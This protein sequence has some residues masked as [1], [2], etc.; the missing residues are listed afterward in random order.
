MHT[1]CE[2]CRKKRNGL[3]DFNIL[4]GMTQSF[5]KTHIIQIEEKNNSVVMI[6]N[7]RRFINFHVVSYD[8]ESSKEIESHT[9][10]EVCATVLVIKYLFKYILKGA[11]Q[12][13]GG[14]YF[15]LRFMEKATV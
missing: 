12:L 5:S 7:G 14:G 11:D 4:R 10:V 13:T 3:K 8:H 6:K 1:A 15:L 2:A 9:S